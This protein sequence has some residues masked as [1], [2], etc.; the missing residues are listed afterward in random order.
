MSG[1][2]TARSATAAG[3]EETIFLP[4]H[5]PQWANLDDVFDDF[6]RRLAVEQS[7]RRALDAKLVEDLSKFIELIDSQ[8]TAEVKVRRETDA[9]LDKVLSPIQNLHLA[10]SA[11]FFPSWLPLA[12][13]QLKNSS[14]I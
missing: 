11:F 9:I 1:A 8:L 7:E 5:P 3:S 10:D 4:L 6:Y 13:M 2:G 14:S 12:S